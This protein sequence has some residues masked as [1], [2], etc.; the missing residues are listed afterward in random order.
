[1][2]FIKKTNNAIQTFCGYLLIL[3]TL[4]VV[5]QVISRKFLGISV[6][7]V[8]EISRY[9]MIWSALLGTAVGIYSKSHVAVEFVIEKI[10]NKYQRYAYIFTYLMM[11]LLL[12]ILVY[13][14][15]NLSIQAMTQRSPSMPF[16]KMGYIMMVVPLTGIIGIINLVSMTVADLKK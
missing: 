8:E 16:L 6:A 7:Q 14:G 2:K 10:S 4:L 1:M 12:V 13:H 9:C 3:M 11:A 5:F 15:T